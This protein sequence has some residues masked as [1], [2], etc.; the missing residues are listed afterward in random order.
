M[1]THALASSSPTLP[2]NSIPA[3]LNLSSADPLVPWSL[4]PS[5]LS[6]SPGDLHVWRFPLDLPPSSFQI[7]ASS[8]L[9]GEIARA[10]RFVF[11][12][13]H[14]HFIAARG[15]LRLLLG[16]YLRTPP[17]EVSLL[18]G[19]H[20]KPFLPPPSARG[21][22]A[23]DLRFNLSHSHG[24]ALCAFALRSELGIDLEKFRPDFASAEIA[25]RFFSPA[26]RSELLSLSPDLHT[27]G[28]FNCWTRKEAYVK[29]RG[30]GLHIPLHSFDVSLAPGQPP[31]LRSA[32][33]ARWSLLSFSPAQDYSA[34]LVAEG[35]DWNVRFFDLPPNLLPLAG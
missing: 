16:S 11:A 24:L 5:S 20:G 31:I 32:D 3:V 9:P 35:S 7:L 26:E 18:K 21:A 33:S 1:N 4:P 25:G 34:A 22:E 27:R 12:S 15:A 28:F 23:P 6:L 8:L 19:P 29:A 10:R 30:Q 17:A 14:D 2:G 13:D